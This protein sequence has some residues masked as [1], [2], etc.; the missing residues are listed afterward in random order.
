[1]RAGYVW[2]YYANLVI[3]LVFQEVPIISPVAEITKPSPSEQSV[4]QLESKFHITHRSPE[5]VHLAYG[6]NPQTEDIE[7]PMS[8]KT[9]SVPS[10]QSTSSDHQPN[11]LPSTASRCN[12]LDSDAALPLRRGILKM[13]YPSGK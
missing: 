12:S 9:S 13:R 8:V 7:A 10:S 2:I 6:E 11:V 1:M 5:C 3:F 4:D